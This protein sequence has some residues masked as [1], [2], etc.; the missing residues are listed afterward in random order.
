M[1]WQGCHDEVHGNTI[2]IQ[3]MDP[4]KMIYLVLGDGKT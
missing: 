3:Y 1:V 2:V 4:E